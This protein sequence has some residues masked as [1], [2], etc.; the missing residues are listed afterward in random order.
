MNE[1][2][3]VLVGAAL[4]FVGAYWL[5]RQAEKRRKKQLRTVA[6]NIIGLEIIHNLEIIGHIEVMFKRSN[7]TL[8]KNIVG[9]MF[10]R[11]S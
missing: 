7:K 2:L 4:G 8:N 6:R 10:L 9:T 5:Q 3:W 1:G 11:T